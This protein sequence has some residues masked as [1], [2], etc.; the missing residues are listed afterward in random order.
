[1]SERPVEAPREDEL[2]RRAS[3]IMAK[4]A[5]GSLERS[6]G[7]AARRGKGD[8]TC[9]R[10][11]VETGKGSSPRR[12]IRRKQGSRASR[13]AKC[14]EG[15]SLTDGLVVAMMRGNARGAK[16]PYRGYSEEGARRAG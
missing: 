16:G 4:A 5:G 14:G 2:E 1:M 10:P 15:E 9:T 3:T 11:W 13:K 7:K 8:G 6:W 12:E